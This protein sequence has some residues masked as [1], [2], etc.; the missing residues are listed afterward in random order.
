MRDRAFDTG[1][2]GQNRAQCCPAIERTTFTGRKE[3]HDEVNMTLAGLIFEGLVAV[4]LVFAVVMCWRVDRRLRALKDGQ[5]GVRDSVI[6]LNEATDRARASLVA[7]ERATT[8]SGDI[9]ERRIQE[10]RRL[11]DELHLMT[12]KAD[13]TANTLAQRPARRRASEVFPDGVG[14]GIHNNLKDVR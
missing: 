13:R 2:H 4:L 3:R 9:L 7:L 12:G 14:S 8:E 6:A 5:D 1:P 10:A 11:S